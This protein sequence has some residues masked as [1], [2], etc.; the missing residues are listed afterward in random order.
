MLG[1]VLFLVRV[2]TV[3][4]LVLSLWDSSVW[5]VLRFIIVVCTSSGFTGGLILMGAGTEGVSMVG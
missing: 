4:R 2:R 5:S 3:L 1:A